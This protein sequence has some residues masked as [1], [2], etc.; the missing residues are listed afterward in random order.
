MA[1]CMYHY[2][3]NYNYIT[4]YLLGTTM[5]LRATKSLSSERQDSML[6]S[7]TWTCR[8]V[9]KIQE[10]GF[11]S[12]SL[13][14]MEMFKTEPIQT[15]SVSSSHIHY[16]RGWGVCR[17]GGRGRRWQCTTSTRR[18]SSWRTKIFSISFS[19][20]FFKPISFQDI[21]NVLFKRTSVFQ[22][23]FNPPFHCGTSGTRNAM[24]DK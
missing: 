3:Y 7:C 8:L 9:A 14:H 19:G 17:T 2:L 4:V 24:E 21:I 16:L 18:G 12:L 15:K 22:T 23:T 13:M 11:K 1:P 20:P 10:W 6:E 5:D